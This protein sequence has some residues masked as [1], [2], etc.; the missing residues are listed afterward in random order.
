MTSKHGARAIHYEF[1]QFYRFS[2]CTGII[3]V[4]PTHV[5]QQQGISH[6]TNLHSTL[7]YIPSTI[8][9]HLTLQG[10]S[11]GTKSCRILQGAKPNSQTNQIIDIYFK[12]KLTP[13]ENV[14]EYHDYRIDF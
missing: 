7:E 2:E 8:N 4:D 10:I 14:R 9:L 6:I 12:M 1:L 11:L 5:I 3:S 13:H